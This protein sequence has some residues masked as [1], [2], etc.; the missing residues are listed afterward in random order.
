MP[1]WELIEGDALGALR[2]RASA[3]F[4]SMVTDPPAGI[5][6]MGKSWDT[7]K[8]GRDQW[9]TWLT[10]V[11]AECHRVLKPGAHILVWALPRTSGWTQR[12]IEDA[13]FQCRDIITHLFG[14]GFPKSLDVSKAIDRKLGVERKVVGYDASR[15]RPATPAAAKWD[16]YGT[17]LKPASE[18]WIL[19]RKPLEGTVASNVLTHGAGALN[20]DGCRIEGEPWT[21]GT[22]TDIRGGGYNSRRPSEGDVFARNV[23][24][25]PGGR[26]PANVILSHSET[27]TDS[28][29]DDCPVKMLDAQ[30]GISQSTQ[31]KP[32]QGQSGAGWGM[33]ATGAEYS[34]VGGASRFFYVAKASRAERNAGCGANDHPTV[35]PIGLMGWLCRL[36]TPPG[37]MVLDPFSG[38]GSTG[39]GAIREGFRFFGIE[40]DAH[41]VQIAQSRLDHATRNRKE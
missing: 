6:F 12:A 13:G 18:H 5:A 38:S 2:E 16:G 20:I 36:I 27:C 22:Q 40:S 33:S 9:I 21:W 17:A 8:G 31:G 39:V 10:G 34:D 11:M 19:A 1:A 41:Y 24:S 25:H 4:D 26:W 28:C 37:G 32:R 7:D 29:A 14:T 3:E 30:S 35:K 23:E 15:A